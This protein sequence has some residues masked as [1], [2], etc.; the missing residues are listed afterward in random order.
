MVTLWHRG[1]A[2]IDRLLGGA[3]PETS[4]A[5]E[6]TCCVPYEIVEKIIAHLIHDH[7]AL[8]ACSLT[9]RSWHAVAV[10]HIYCTLAF[11]SGTRLKI[12]S[13]LHKRG[14]IPFVN[15][16]H[17]YHP[18]AK[19]GWFAPKAFSPR[20]LYYFSALANVHTL[21]LQYTKIHHFIPGVERYFGHFSQ[22]LQSIFLSSPQCTP[23][24]LS[25]FL[26][27][28]SNLDNIN[29][30]G[31][32]TP[33]RIPTPD[34]QLVPFSVP[35]LQ[36]QLTLYNFQ[37]VETWTHLISPGGLRFCHLDLAGSTDC[38]PVLLEACAETLET[39]ELWATDGKLCYSGSSAGSN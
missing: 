24:Q 14:L 26:S 2:K 39:L 18:R 20:D 19:R 4:T 5:H 12:L 8:R 22:T 3:A 10:P 21:H 9:C 32:C 17:V 27:L 28:F 36:G 16:I 33:V 38:A 15:E 30:L 13:K 29:I 31:D 11:G 6:S 37:S 7:S 34:T 23:R 25:H 35:K 1:K